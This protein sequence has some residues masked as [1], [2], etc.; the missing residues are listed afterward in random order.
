MSTTKPFALL[1][2]HM[3]IGG[4][5]TIRLPQVEHIN[6]TLMGEASDLGAIVSKFYT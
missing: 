3:L 4:I 1:K 6:S 5:R 2:F